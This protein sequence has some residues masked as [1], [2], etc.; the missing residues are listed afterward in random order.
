MGKRLRVCSLSR[1]K[2]CGPPAD[3]SVPESGRA[4]ISYE[5]L[6]VKIWIPMVGAGS[7]AVTCL[8]VCS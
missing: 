3:M 2:S 8:M 4:S 6:T 7:A 5:P 1:F